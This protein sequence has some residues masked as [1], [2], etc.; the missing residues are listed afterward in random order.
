MKCCSNQQQVEQ[1]DN[2]FLYQPGGKCK[3]KTLTL[4]SRSA[5]INSSGIWSSLKSDHYSEAEDS[6]ENAAFFQI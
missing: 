2:F 3:V 1:V 6:N 5:L 4:A